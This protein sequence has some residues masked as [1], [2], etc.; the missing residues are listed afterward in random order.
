MAGA[1][2]EVID[3]IE[4]AKHGIGSSRRLIAATLDDLSQHHSWLETYHRDERLRAER[5]RRQ[6]F[7]ERLALIRQRAAERTNRAARTAYQA[8]RVAAKLSK[9]HTLAFLRWAAPRARTASRHAATTASEAWSWT[10]RRT[11]E[12]THR[13]A[14]AAARGFNWS[15]RASDDAGYVFRRRMAAVYAEAAAELAR[16]TAP[17][18]RRGVSAW[19]RARLRAR[20]GRAL[21]E[22]HLVAPIAGSPSLARA[23]KSLHRWTIRGQRGGAHAAIEARQQMFRLESDLSAWIVRIVPE[24]R[25]RWRPTCRTRS[26]PQGRRA[27]PPAV[28]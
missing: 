7:L 22:Q 6:R 10:R 18:R 25:R 16:R 28:P 26:W 2:R 15:V 9:R 4:A 12:F 5:L 27:A 11:P 19:A 21:A 3:P 14:E 8:G 17:M 23:Q 20:R 1:T 24:L 13:G